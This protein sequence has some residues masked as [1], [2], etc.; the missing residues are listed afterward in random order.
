[1]DWNFNVSDFL[2]NMKT[3]VEYLTKQVI[4]A[5]EKNSA[6][7]GLFVMSFFNLYLPLSL[8][9]V[10]GIF[11]VLA[12]GCD[13]YGGSAVSCPEKTGFWYL[14]K[15]TLGEEQDNLT[16][17]HELIVLNKR[18]QI[19]SVQKEYL[20]HLSAYYFCPREERCRSP[21]RLIFIFEI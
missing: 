17:K 4:P 20:S 18:E 13:P 12:Y 14:F 2:K 16:Q 8:F 11:Y 21:P 19:I 5:K 7:A 3:T 10:R 15:K 9:W 6:L 1:M